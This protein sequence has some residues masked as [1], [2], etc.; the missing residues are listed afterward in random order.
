ML[1]GC[2]SM[3]PTSIYTMGNLSRVR[4]DSSRRPEMEKPD[5]TS[6]GELME[7]LLRERGVIPRRAAAGLERRDRLPLPAALADLG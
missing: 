4:E 5:A 3:A 2:P 1:A 7:N 6:L